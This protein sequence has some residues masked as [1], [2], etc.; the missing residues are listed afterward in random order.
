MKN[1]IS[2]FLI[3]FLLFSS[4]VIARS[5]KNIII[6]IGDG[7]GINQVQAAY[8]QNGGYLNMTNRCPFSG[9]RQTNSANKYT[10]DSAA[11]GT[12][13]ACGEKT[14]NG[15][16]GMSADSIPMNSIIRLATL[17]GMSTGVISTSSITDATPASF[18]AHQPVR[19]MQ[20]EIAEDFLNSDISLFIGGG[21]KFFEK[22]KDGRNISKELTDKGYKMAYTL[23][24]VQPVENGKLGVLMAEDGLKPVK[25]RPANFLP[26]ATQMALDLL[27]KNKKGFILM[28][29]GSQI[30]WAGHNN[31][32]EWMVNEMLDFDHAVGIALD[33]AERDGDTLVLITADHETGGVT[34]ANGDYEKKEI[35]VKYNTGGHSAS[36][37]PFFSYGSGAE[38]FSGFK[39]NTAS[40]HIMKKLLKL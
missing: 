25:E 29:E 21:L 28:V 33:F 10:T 16:V 8:T 4:A 18:V 11:G 13:I 19:S 6:L 9:L 24:D 12:A 7:M 38:L 23:E 14:N 30:D 3:L 5:P 40:F 17:K 34:I 26:D 39:D 1:K 36:P 27:S 22:R 35:T 32:K 2:L 20:E 15:M 37:V 31:D